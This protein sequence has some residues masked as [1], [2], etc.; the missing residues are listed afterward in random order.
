[1]N[2]LLLSLLKIE[3]NPVTRRNR[4]LSGVG[5]SEIS[6]CALAYYYSSVIHPSKL[7]LIDSID[8]YTD[9]GASIT[10][11][12]RTLSLSSP[13]YNLN[14]SSLSSLLQNHHLILLP[15]L[16]YQFVGY[17]PF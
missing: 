11:T 6:T 17:L 2:H 4:I 12:S 13:N 7:S 5:V 16:T 8:C 1:M 15:S 3:T 10:A 9:I 14:S